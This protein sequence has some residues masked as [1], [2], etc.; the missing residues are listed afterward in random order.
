MDGAATTNLDNKHVNNRTKLLKH[1][2]LQFSLDNVANNKEVAQTKKY[3][4]IIIE[5]KI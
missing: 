2:P 3:L 5:R 4:N 1:E